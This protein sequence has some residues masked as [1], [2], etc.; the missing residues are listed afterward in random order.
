MIARDDC[1]IA[2]IGTKEP[3]LRFP[4]VLE[5]E[6]VFPTKSSRV[7]VHIIKFCNVVGEVFIILVTILTNLSFCPR[8]KIF[9]NMKYVEPIVSV[10]FAIIVPYPTVLAESVVVIMKFE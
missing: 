8:E 9:W 7:P 6:S 4:L 10:L 3:V 5:F 2:V 1:P